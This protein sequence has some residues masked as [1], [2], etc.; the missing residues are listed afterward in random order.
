MGFDLDRR[1]F[2][3]GSAALVTAASL[4]LRARAATNLKYGN[5]GN[6]DTLSNRFWFKLAEEVE[7]RS[8][9]E[10]TIEIFAGTLGG[11]KTLIE[12]MALGTIDVYNGAYTGTREFD[13]LYS[14]YMFRDGAHAGAV[15]KGPIGEQA[16]QTLTERYQAKM[17]GV[18]R[19]GP[20]ALF[21]NEPLTSLDDLQGRKIRTPQI[22][23]CIKAVEHLGGT[24]T[25]V[26]FNEVYLALQ[27]GI[28]DGLV[29]ALNVAVAVKFY[30][31]AEYVLSNQFG[32]ALDKNLIAVRSWEQLSPELQDLLVS[33]FEALEEQDYYQAGVES[34]QQDL[35]TWREKNGE[36][37][38]LTLD[39]AQLEETMAPLNEELANEVYGEGAWETIQST[40]G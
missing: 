39:Q 10:L 40:E 3:L 19:L 18:G 38:V 24:P 29:T 36:D 21:V 6:A 11:E 14:P 33:S 8:N 7:S 12:G 4:P 2:G 20:F 1:R 32:E 9:G 15:M 5:A 25:P 30:E 28:V 34:V 26:A 23:G 16:A 35:A 22:E 37:A 17:L 31:V 13:I 27:Q